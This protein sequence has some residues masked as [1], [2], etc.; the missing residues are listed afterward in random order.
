MVFA[1]VEF[2]SEG[3]EGE[4]VLAEETQLKDGFWVGEVE[5]GEVCV[6]TGVRGAE[7]GYSSCGGDAGA[8]LG[9]VSY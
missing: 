5:A 8:D 1:R 6:E 9:S 2:V 7:V 3:V 4:R